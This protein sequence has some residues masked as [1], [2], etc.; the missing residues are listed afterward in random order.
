MIVK[1]QLHFKIKMHLNALGLSALFF[2]A[3]KHLKPALIA[4][5]VDRFN[6][7]NIKVRVG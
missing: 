6:I 4:G 2:S 5:P 1:A 3:L 7:T